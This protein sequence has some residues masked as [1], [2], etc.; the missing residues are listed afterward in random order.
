M[1]DQTLAN[2]LGGRSAT[3]QLEFNCA[4]SETTVSIAQVYSGNSLQG[5]P[6]KAI[7]ASA[8]M[9]ANDDL[10][11]HDRVDIVGDERRADRA[12][13]HELQD[14]P[15]ADEEMRGVM[16]AEHAERALDA[17]ALRRVDH[18]GARPVEIDR[19]AEMRTRNL[20]DRERADLVEIGFD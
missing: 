5:G 12:D 20:L 7:P 11:L 1:I 4:L 16:R 19:L 14:A 10:D 6:P 8:W 2:S 13:L 18:A 17:V 15:G 9:S 3:L